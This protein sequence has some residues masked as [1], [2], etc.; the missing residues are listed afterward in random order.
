[1]LQILLNDTEKLKNELKINLNQKTSQITGELTDNFKVWLTTLFF[2]YRTS[3]NL[4]YTFAITSFSPNSGSIRGG[5][6]LN[7]NG[8]G[9][10]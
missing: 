2:N 10:R 3:T 6:I 4:V 5:T 9:F 1:M 8:A 7:I